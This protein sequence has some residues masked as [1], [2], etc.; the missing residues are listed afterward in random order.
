M[1]NGYYSFEAGVLRPYIGGGIGLV[2]HD[3]TLRELSASGVQT[4]EYDEDDTVLAYQ[5]MIGIAYP[6]SE[7]SEVRLGYRYFGTADADFDGTEVSYGTHNIEAGFL[8]RF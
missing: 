4:A 2:R 7:A 8:F 5:A 1:A 6:M 3:G